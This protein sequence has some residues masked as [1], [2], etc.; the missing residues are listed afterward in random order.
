MESPPLDDTRKDLVEDAGQNELDGEGRNGRKEDSIIVCLECS[1]CFC[2][3]C[4]KDGVQLSHRRMSSIAYSRASTRR[5][6]TVGARRASTIVARRASVV[7][8][9]KAQKA[10][11][12]YGFPPGT[13][14][15]Y[16]SLFSECVGLIFLPC[17]CSLLDSKVGAAPLRHLH[18]RAHVLLPT[19]RPS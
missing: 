18:P 2:A 12:Q 13:F 14:T 1:D 3:D 4:T 11:C 5:A 17:R 9:P 15:E 16:I 7:V 19:G 10:V 8:P 6:S